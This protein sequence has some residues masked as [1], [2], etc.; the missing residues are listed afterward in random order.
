MSLHGLYDTV[1]HGRQQMICDVLVVVPEVK[2]RQLELEL[3]DEQV[4]GEH[5]FKWVCCGRAWVLMLRC[6]GE[7]SGSLRD[8]KVSQNTPGGPRSDRLEGSPAPVLYRGSNTSNAPLG[9]NLHL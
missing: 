7:S 9:P 3:N 1:T 6:R 2:C 4:L 8:L 5:S